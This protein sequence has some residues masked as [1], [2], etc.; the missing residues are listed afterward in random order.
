MHDALTMYFNGEKYAGL[1][2][3]GFA[4]FAIAVAVLLY[5]SGGD[6]RSFAMTLGIIALAEIALGVGLYARTGPQARGLEDQL[7]SDATVFY[8]EESTRMTR[9]QKN[10]VIIEYVELVVIIACALAAVALKA[11]PGPSG[12][13]LGLLINASVLLA[14]DVL[15]ERRGADYVAAL[16]HRERSTVS[17]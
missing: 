1:V 5:R 10:F 6:L 17:R 3:A 9:V 4:I 11:K 16:T 12:V 8:A 7:R 13:A 15:A 14:F 2:L